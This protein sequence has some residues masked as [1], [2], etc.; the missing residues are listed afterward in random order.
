MV[1]PSRAKGAS[2]PWPVYMGIGGSKREVGL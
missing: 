1:R 2:W